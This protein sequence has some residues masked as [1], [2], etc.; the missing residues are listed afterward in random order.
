[1]SDTNVKVVC[2]FRPQNS[3]ERAAQGVECATF[4]SDQTCSIMSTD[5]GTKAPQTKKFTF[6]HIFGPTSTQQAVYHV[7]ARPVV[8]DVM[9]GY[10]GT[11]FAY[12]QTS[13]GKT[14][15]MQGPDIDNPDDRGIIPRIIS[16]IFEA[17]GGSKAHLEFTVQVS[18]VEIYNEKIR[19]LL[20]PR[21]SNLVIHESPTKGIYIA[22]V[23]EQYVASPD[24]TVGPYKG[25]V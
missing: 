17:I 9:Q 10:N 22:D 3:K 14:H 16:H 2:R 23:C 19:D 6:D 11:I 12:G 24:E 1:M 25:V 13:S 21:K 5:G 8:E 18:Y 4:D 15:T 7:A 20:D